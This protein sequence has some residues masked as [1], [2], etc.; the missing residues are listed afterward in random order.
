MKNSTPKYFLFFGFAAVLVACSTKKDAF[1]NRKFHALNTKYNI[2]YN[3]EVAM[4]QGVVDLRN[5]YKDNFWEVLPVE[6]MQV[7]EEKA[8]PGDT[9]NPNFDRAETKAIKAIQKH[10]MNI[11][12]VERNPQ[13]DEAHLMLGQARYYEQRFVPALE[14]FNY[15]LYKY[16]QSD[17]INLVKIWR[18]KTNMR[19]ENDELAVNNLRKL[20]KEIKFK[21]QVYADANATLAQAFINLKEIDSAIAKLRLATEFTK[22]DEEKS[23]YRFITAQLYEDRGQKDSAFI[24]YQRVIDMNRKAARQYVIQAHA[25][26]A[27]Q[28]NPKTGDTVAF[29]KK[30]KDLMEDR[31]NRP[32]MDVLHHQMALYYEKV[33]RPKQAKLSYNASLK[34]K[35]QDQYLVASNYRNLAELHFN[36]AK[37]VVAGKYFD[38]TLTVLNPRTRE[39]RLITKKRENLQDVIKFEG[40]AQR[41]DSILNLTGMSLADREAFFQKHIERLKKEEAALKL[42]AEK[43]AQEKAA[44]E[45]NAN[46]GKDALGADKLG[47]G[48]K[49]VITPVASSNEV[50][51]FYFYNP[52]TVEIGKVEFGKKWGKRTYGENWRWSSTVSKGANPDKEDENANAE[53][54]EEVKTVNPMHTTEF[55]LK[56]LPTNAKVLDSLAKERN[57][58]YYQLGVIYKEKFKEYTRSASKFEQLLKNKPEERLVLPSLYNLYKVYQI[59]DP[60][61]AAA[62]K[63]RILNEYPDTRYAQIVGGNTSAAAIATTPEA[64][65]DA[66]Y[67]AYDSGKYREVLPQTEQAIEQFTGEE[68]VPKYELLKAQLLGKLKGLSEYKKALNY[69]ALTY[70]NS[71]EGKKTELFIQKKIPYL[72]SLSFNSEP[73]TSWNIVYPVVFPTTA[74]T[75]KLVDKLKKFIQERTIETMTLSEDIYMLDKNFVV[76]HGIKNLDNAKGIAQVLK[77]FK[78]YKIAEPYAIISNENY[79]VVQVMKNFEDYVSGDWL[80]KPIVPV[81]RTLE[82]EKEIPK[83]VP[84][85]KNSGTVTK[86][87]LFGEDPAAPAG[88]TPKGTQ[89][90]K[91]TPTGNPSNPVPATKSNA[92]EDAP[93]N[94]LPPAPGFNPNKK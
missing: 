6:R 3:G 74:A 56:Q 73:V 55:Y 62:I 69:V 57:F 21:D 60:T 5:Q 10:S 90:S 20:L 39:F 17:K 79:K 30:Y 51:N 46:Q 58:A 92:A 23:R 48:K 15:V 93:M 45:A 29:L 11:D 76:L 42:M 63:S 40:I 43:L 65:Y 32:F 12:G 44:A 83:V 18:E 68:L 82:I 85:G 94:A 49:N 31:E 59:I 2:L 4:D 38:S 26:Q 91:P 75:Q 67:R 27:R 84:K 71:E 25:R 22:L 24:E 13:M 1:V 72:E 8:L 47:G 87:E 64:T 14:A 28:F 80:N 86:E 7:T 33:N 41:N 88:D 9:K 34:A 35:P 50:S 54:E 66:L 37:Y 77:E 78:D 16:P 19:L 70:P 52:N 36:E 81:Q 53:K 89:G 61:K